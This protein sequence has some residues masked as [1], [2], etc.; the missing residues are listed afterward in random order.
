MHPWVGCGFA[1]A[2]YEGSSICLAW[3]GGSMQMHSAGCW[4]WLKVQRG[5]IH[6]S[7]ASVFLHVA[8]L[9][10]CGVSSFS[11]LVH[12]SLQQAAGFT[13]EKVEAARLLNGE[14]QRWH[15]FAFYHSGNVTVPA[16]TQQE[17]S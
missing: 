2:Q 16:L 9:I 1:G 6:V 15:T 4:A 5:C 14:D 10:P 13:R 8:F 17:G 7:G 3:V 12:V 11:S